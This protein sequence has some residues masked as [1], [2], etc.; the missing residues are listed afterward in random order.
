MKPKGVILLVLCIA[1]SL[2]GQQTGSSGAGP[3]TIVVPTVVYMGTV[4]QETVPDTSHPPIPPPQPGP[5]RSNCP[6]PTRGNATPPPGPSGGGPTGAPVLGVPTLG[7]MTEIVSCAVGPS[8]TLKAVDYSVTV[9]SAWG[10]VQAGF[11]KTVNAILGLPADAYTGRPSVA[12]DAGNNRYVMIV[13]QS[14]SYGQPIAEWI[15]ISQGGDPTQAWKILRI[16]AQ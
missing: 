1:A 14:D 9:V 10:V 13:D 7:A 3:P 2:F 12:Y 15:A 5:V 8:Y 16:Q 4:P 6:P 11:P